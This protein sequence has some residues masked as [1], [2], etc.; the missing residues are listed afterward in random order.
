[1]TYEE[2]M[3]FRREIMPKPPEPK[4]VEPVMSLADEVAVAIGGGVA[5]GRPNYVHFDIVTNGMVSMEWKRCVP[6]PERYQ[7]DF[8][9]NP[10]SREGMRR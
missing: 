2:E 1:M 8:D 10:F 4:P 3:E 7:A 6:E 9:Y 5:V